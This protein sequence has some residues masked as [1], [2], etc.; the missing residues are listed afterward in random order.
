MSTSAHPKWL[1]S[2]S[3]TTTAPEWPEAEAAVPRNRLYVSPELR[4]R[5]RGRAPAGDG[6]SVDT[7]ALYMARFGRRR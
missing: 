5:C 2:Q 4:A 3:T 6:G 1:A 7:Y